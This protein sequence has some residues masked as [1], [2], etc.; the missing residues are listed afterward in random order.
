MSGAEGPSN[1]TRQKLDASDEPTTAPPL[2]SITTH[3][4][5]SPRADRQ[6]S[7][8]TPGEATKAFLPQSTRDD[9]THVETPTAPAPPEPQTI[10]SPPREP[11]E[12][13]PAPIPTHVSG[14]LT[15]GSGSS[16]ASASASSTRPPPTTHAVLPPFAPPS[17]Y[18]NSSSS[19]NDEQRR[20]D[21]DASRLTRELWDTRRELRAMQA[22]EQVILDDLERLGA[23]PEGTAGTDLNGVSRDELVRLE[24][25]LRV[26]RARRVRAERVLSDVER[27]C[28]APFVVPA[29]LQ[30]F[31]SISELSN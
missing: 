2:R 8:S 25:E 18:L 19:G 23:R 24:A 21:R 11:G 6:R 15:L 9:A 5:T 1:L 14:P 16:L 20:R 26:E 10:P 31:M 27:E 3:P 28:R 17:P 22:R 12:I 4:P 30:A 29:L 13:H 7:S